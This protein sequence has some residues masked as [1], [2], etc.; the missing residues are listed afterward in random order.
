MKKRFIISI[1]LISLL[2][3]IKV[4]A[5][6]ICTSS[7]YTSLKREAYKVELSWEL[8]FDEK[9]NYY[10]QVNVL[11]MNENVLLIFNDTV[12]EGQKDGAPFL[13]N[14]PLEGG[15][16]YEFKFYGGYSNPCSE[17]YLYT[18]NLNLPKYNKYSELEECIEYEEFPLCNKWY[19]G[20]IKDEEYFLEQLEIYKKS[21]EPTQKPEPNIDNR[22][23]FE[24]IIDFYIDNLIITLPITIAL[25]IL[26]AVIVIIRV[27]RSK[28]RVKINLD[29]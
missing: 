3:F 11:N 15:N 13:I 16:T 5:A 20:D 18:K 14:T 1:L 6:D 24:K 29:I 17:E 21:L 12:Y 9:K 22:N 2:G 19:S 4:E 23:I 26:I 28:K 10:F 8:K 27:V 25:V 7:K